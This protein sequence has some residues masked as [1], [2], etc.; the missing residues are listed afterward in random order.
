[1]YNENIR[2][3]TTRKN[4]NNE[5]TMMFGNS[6][7]YQNGLYTL[8]NTT[9]AVF[10]TAHLNLANYHYT[11]FNTSGTC[12][13]ISYIYYRGTD[14]WARYINLSGGKSVEDALNDMLYSE[15]VNQNDS[16]IKKAIDYWYK[17]NMTGYTKYLEDTI[18]CNDR[19]MDNT[20]NNGWNPNGGPF[21]QTT[22]S[23]P[24]L[25]F[26]SANGSSNNLNLIC[27]NQND[28]FTINNQ[29]GNGRLKYPVGLITSQEQKLAFDSDASPLAS[30][31]TYW[32]SSPN[33]YTEVGVYSLLVSETGNVIGSY[34]NGKF[35]VRPSVSLRADIEYSS[36]D[37]SINNP[38]II[39]TD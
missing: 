18:W 39:P 23:R 5:G 16:N 6:F 32:G 9:S 33:T 36:G 37:G 38:Y 29:L 21:S 20:N 19:S 15:T 2:Y 24:Y 3:E 26:G 34:T 31:N 4:M 7:T 1:M 12:A 22:T 35:G 14:G 17:N 13:T 30:G 27:K 25:V 11:C 10:S 28:R 8:K